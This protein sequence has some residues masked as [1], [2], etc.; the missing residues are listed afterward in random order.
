MPEL[1]FNPRLSEKFQVPGSYPGAAQ[2][3]KG[4]LDQIGH[5]V[6]TVLAGGCLQIPGFLPRFV[7]EVG[8]GLACLA[9]CSLQRPYASWLGGR[10]LASM[11]GISS[12]WMSKEQYAEEGIDRCMQRMVA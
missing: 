10:I 9:P 6:R 4:L 8:S 2:A 1:F 12:L 3:V 7:S 11:G 5:P